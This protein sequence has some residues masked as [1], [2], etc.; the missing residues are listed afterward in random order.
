MLADL[1]GLSDVFFPKWTSPIWL[2]PKGGEGG[3]KHFFIPRA[4]FRHKPGLPKES[5]F[6]N[7]TLFFNVIPAKAGI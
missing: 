7:V 2:S 4:F 5:Y 1:S 6:S 3:F